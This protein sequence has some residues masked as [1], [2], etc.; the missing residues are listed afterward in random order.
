MSAR[1]V[2]AE[3]VLPGGAVLRIVEADSDGM[4]VQAEV[5]DEVVGCLV[6]DLDDNAA[7]L[8]DVTVDVD[9]RGQ[10]IG[11]TLLQCATDLLAASG[12]HTLAA[13]CPAEIGPW[14]RR[15][16]FAP[17]GAT[18]RAAV[19]TLVE[20]PTADAMRT[21]GERLAPLLAPGDVIIATGDLGAGKTTLTQGIG[22]GLGAAGPVISPT[23]VLSRVHPS[24]ADGPALVHVDAYRLGSFDELED[25]DLEASLADS[26]TVIEWGGGIAEGLADDR[27]EIDIRRGLDPDDETR[28]VF[29]AGRGQRWAAR[30]LESLR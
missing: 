24:T 23:F 21:L 26:V 11:T 5:N 27:L 13:D 28:L 12:V 19:P 29:L 18:L 20:V 15:H 4:T 10:G 2:I 16:G 9:H 25:L 30:Q 14:L 7:T 6:I 1:T 22:V 3:A 17:E 8:R